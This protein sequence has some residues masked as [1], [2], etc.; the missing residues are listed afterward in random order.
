[1]SL[2]RDLHNFFFVPKRVHKPAPKLYGFQYGDDSTPSSEA[3]WVGPYASKEEAIQSRSHWQ[4]EQ[5]KVDP[6]VYAWT[7]EEMPE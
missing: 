2:E 4:E 5:D 7:I 6:D 1:M 3:P